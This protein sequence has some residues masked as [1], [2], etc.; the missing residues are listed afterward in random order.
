MSSKDKEVL[1]KRLISQFEECRAQ[2]INVFK[3]LTEN[4]TRIQVDELR[5]PLI[6]DL[7]HSAWFEELWI[8][9]NAFN[10]KKS[11][12]HEDPCFDNELNHKRTRQTMRLPYAQELFDY[13]KNIRNRTLTRL[14]KTPFDDKNALLKNGFVF[15]LVLQHEHQHRELTFITLQQLL[16]FPHPSLSKGSFVSEIN[17]QQKQEWNPGAM[18]EIPE[19]E[20]TLGALD[21]LF[22]YDNEKPAHQVTV[23]KFKMDQFKTS[24]KEFLEFINAD[25]YNNQE[26]WTDKGWSWIKFNEVTC[27]DYWRNDPNTGWIRKGFGGKNNPLQLDHPVCNISWYEAMAYA[28]FRGKRLT[29]EAEWEWAAALENSDSTKR[30]YPWGEAPPTST[31]ANLDASRLGP[32]PVWDYADGDSSLGLRQM[33]GNVWEWTSS[34][35]K[36]YQ[37]FKAFPYPEYSEIFMRHQLKVLKGASWATSPT[38]VRNT[39][40]NFYLPHHRHVIAGIRLVK[41]C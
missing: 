22:A 24:N 20:F 3:G 2:M 16:A 14:E 1:R 21:T 6:W 36:P 19:G 25:G 4:E 41:D 32:C 35:F 12:S 18:V 8:L 34:P 26:F 37:N 30:F 9:R 5:G 40:R 31:H 23:S 10:E 11:W 17:H 27:P 28:K 29:T 39:F 33:V 38:L 7:G 13:A 15:D